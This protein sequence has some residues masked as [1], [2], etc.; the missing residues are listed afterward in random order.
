MRGRL[1][2]FAKR[3]RPH[4]A[5]EPECAALPLSED[6][7]LRAERPRDNPL[8]APAEKGG[9]P[10]MGEIG[11]H[12]FVPYLLNRI[13]SRWNAD[14]Q[15]ALRAFDMTTTKMRVLAVL[16]VSS[17][18]TINELS[19][20]AVTEQSTMSRTLDA[21]EEQGLIRR[22]ARADDM[23]VREIHISE[24]G[25]ALFGRI[26]PGMYAMYRAMFDGVDEAEFRTLTWTL[27]KVLRNMHAPET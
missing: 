5:Q 15:E 22:Q 10:T 12:Q 16:S 2:R 25:R 23:R 7:A 20:Y 19:V 8:P 11:L 17:A 26:W 24:E 9:I 4:L 27:Q 1:S 3:A 21:M 14:M 13:S 18:M 6:D